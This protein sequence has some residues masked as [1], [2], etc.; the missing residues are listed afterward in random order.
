M[1]EVFKPSAGPRPAMCR[2][3][4]PAKPAPVAPLVA[5]AIFQN[6]VRSTAA[7]RAVKCSDLNPLLDQELFGLDVVGSGEQIGKLEQCDGGTLLLEETQL[8]PLV[9]SKL[10]RLLTTGSFEGGSFGRLIATNIRLLCTTSQDLEPLVAQ[11]LFQRRFVL[12]CDLCPSR[13]RRSGA[14]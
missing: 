1:S 7:F 8:S 2:C 5:R 12:R 10:F 13:C 3:S 11:R 4:F 9:Q 6:K 14:A